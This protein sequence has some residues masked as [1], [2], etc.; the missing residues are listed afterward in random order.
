MPLLAQ[1]IN[2]YQD[3]AA[4]IV[5]SNLIDTRDAFDLTLSW[6]TA[7]GTSSVLSYQI[8]NAS[9]NPAFGESIPEASWSHYTLFGLLGIPSTSTFFEPPLGFRWARCL[10]TVSGGSYVIEI[11]KFVR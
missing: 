10:R 7:S 8:S 9:Q 2:P 5:T 11:N 1:Y 3:L 6:R 4:S